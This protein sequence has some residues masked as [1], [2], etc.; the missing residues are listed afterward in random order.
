M[1]AVSR[2]DG[3]DEK[4]SLEPLSSW[5]GENNIRYLVGKIGIPGTWGWA[6]ITF[7][8]WLEKSVY[9]VPRYLVLNTYTQYTAVYDGEYH[10]I[11]HHWGG[12]PRSIV[13][14]PRGCQCRTIRLRKPLGEV[15]ATPVCLAPEQLQVWKYRAWKIGLRGCDVHRRIR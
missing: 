6:K 3:R 7:G 9:Q 13:R 15:F 14:Q 12:F 1:T 10:T 8:I 4:K 2:M 11:K 5:L